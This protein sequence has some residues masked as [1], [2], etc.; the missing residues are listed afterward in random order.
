LIDLHLR[1]G[2]CFAMELIYG[3]AHLAQRPAELLLLFAFFLNLSQG[4]NAERE[5][6]QDAMVI[7]NSMSENPFVSECRL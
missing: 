5:N 4:D 1:A 2:N 7:T 3:F 6:R